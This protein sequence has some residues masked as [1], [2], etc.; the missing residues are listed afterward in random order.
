MEFRTEIRTGHAFALDTSILT[1]VSK[2]V[3]QGQ[4]KRRL[5]RASA[6]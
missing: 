1:A 5:D 4:G 6:V 3:P 2:A